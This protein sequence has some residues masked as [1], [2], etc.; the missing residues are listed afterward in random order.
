MR[1]PITKPWSDAEFKRPIELANQ[2]ASLSRCSGAFSRSSIS[3]A[4]KLRKL[5]LPVRGTMVVK[6][7]QREKFANEETL[8]DQGIWRNAGTRI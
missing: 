1:K 4:A 6:K 5:G 3:I 8:L 7:E 2:G